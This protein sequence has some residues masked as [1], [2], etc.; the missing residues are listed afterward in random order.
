MAIQLRNHVAKLS[1]WV[2]DK[3]MPLPTTDPH[4]WHS[5][6]KRL[7][8]KTTPSDVGVLEEHGMLLLPL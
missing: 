8:G 3:S 1:R 2:K 6:V 5:L 4:K 7:A